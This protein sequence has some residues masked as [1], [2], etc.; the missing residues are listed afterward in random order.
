MQILWKKEIEE[1][2]RSG[3][4]KSN[5]TITDALIENFYNEILDNDDKNLLELAFSNTPNQ[6]DLD[7]I[8]KI[9]DIEKKDSHKSLLLA[10]VLKRHPKLKFTDYESPR[11]KGL[12]QFFRFKNIELISHFV[13]ITRK[14]NENNIY[15]LLIKGGAI[16]YLIPDLPRIMG[17]IDILVN[18]KDYLKSVN[19]AVS[20]GYYHKGFGGHSVDLYDKRTN[21]NTVD[22]HKFI[23]MGTKKDKKFSN[24][25]FERAIKHKAF[26]VEVLIPTIEDMMFITLVNLARNLREK[27]S[28]KG[29]IY[30]LFDCKFFLENKPDFNWETVKRNA[31]LTNT[32]IQINF[33]MKFIN[34]ISA[35]ILPFEFQKRTLFE[36]LTNDYSNMVM[37]NRFYL[38]DI[39]KESRALKI[40]EIFFDKNIFFKYLKI[41][42]KYFFLKL[43]KT[44]PR[45]IE[46]LIKDLK[47]KTYSFSTLKG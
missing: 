5:I 2:S 41:K 43:L 31:K 7:K 29:L 18:K 35:D 32:E 26:G 47:N 11:L 46:I 3:Y 20:L 45:L 19:L 8:L 13:K 27:T 38:E 23:E 17:D 28:Q 34:K 42:P 44:H 25:L 36:K 22:I 10:Y 6:N 40:K 30:S 21:K 4:L 1:I 15:P 33:A 12:L 37:F 16:K 9:W 39:R 24:F 14:L